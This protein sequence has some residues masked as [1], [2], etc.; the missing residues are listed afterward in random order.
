LTFN[1]IF[2]NY[3]SLT[4]LGADQLLD[5]TIRY[6]DGRTRSYTS[7]FEAG[8][9]HSVGIVG[10]SIAKSNLTNLQAGVSQLQA[11]LY[12]DITTNANK[13]SVLGD[14]FYAGTLGYF[15]MYNALSHLQAQS[16]NVSHM[17]MPSLGTYGA[18]A[19]VS[20]LFGF[21]RS[22]SMG[23]IVMDVGKLVTIS[24]SK[25]GNNGRKLSFVL[26]AG[27]LSSLLEHAVPEQ[28]FS[29]ATQKVEA[30]STV[31]LLQLAAQQG[32]PILHVTQEN[33]SIAIPRL[34]L[35]SD[36]IAEIQS[37]IASGNEVIVHQKNI[38]NFGWVG[39]GY[40]IINPETGDGAYRISEGGNGGFF[41]A[42]GMFAGIVFAKSVLYL[43]VYDAMIDKTGTKSLVRAAGKFA[44]ITGF[45][46]G[47]F[48][49]ASNCNDQG[50]TEVMMGYLL[51]SGIAVVGIEIAMAAAGGFIVAAALPFLAFGLG[52]A[53][54]FI[55]ANLTTELI[56]MNPNCGPG[57]GS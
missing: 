8:T 16:V 32:I 35:N 45:L 51:A 22:F 31:K 6:P 52:V 2:F 36:V 43:E 9:F 10:G 4:R 5:Y 28:M 20:Y 49:I 24:N 50:F 40:A 23:G 12:A 57:S 38:S 46:I 47:M 15:A 11:D 7:N 37:A 27:I 19:N 14:L 39:V 1:T 3:S 41:D 53:A 33:S 21:P 42:I 34:Q 44:G 25:D 48:A 13:E 55:I 26:Q 54:S 56:N 30:I 17:L 18:N 29:T